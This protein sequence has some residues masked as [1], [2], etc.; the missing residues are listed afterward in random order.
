MAAGPNRP[1]IAEPEARRL[2][3][4]TTI[5][6]LAAGGAADLR[7][8][9]FAG[10]PVADV[11]AEYRQ[12]G[13]RVVYST[14]LVPATKR[15]VKDPRG[16]DPIVRLSS[17]LESQGLKLRPEDNGERWLVVRS[18]Q[19]DDPGGLVHGTV[20]DRRTGQPIADA[21]V[22]MQGQVVTTDIRGR[23]S[24]VVPDLQIPVI[25]QRDGYEDETVEPGATAEDGGLLTIALSPSS[26]VE[27]ILV[28]SP[29]YAL[30]KIERSSRYYLDADELMD[31]PELGD[32]ALR[33]ATHLPGAASIG[34]SARPHIRG[35]YADETLILF[36]QVELIE[37]FHLKDFQSIFSGFSPSLVKSIDVYTGGFP[38]RYGDRMSG[39]MDVDVT[40]D[41]EELG[42]QVSLSLLSAEALGYGS[43]GDK[44]DWALSA[45]RG[46]LD[47]VTKA[48]NPGLGEPSYSDV[49][50]QFGWEFNID[51][52]VDFGVLAY[53][54]DIVI[55]TF[56]EEGAGERAQSNY[57]NAYAW[58]QMH[59]VWS[60][61][62]DST[63]TFS[64]GR[65]RSDRFGI[66]VDDDLADASGTFDSRQDVDV[67]NLSY[68]L[69]SDV[70]TE[71]VGLVSTEVGG[72]LSY[73][74]A[75]YDLV[76]DAETSE[77]G[78]LIGN[79]EP[80][81]RAIDISPEGL[82]G[83]LFASVRL[84]PWQKLALETGVRWDFQEYGA[85]GFR[86]QWGPRFSARYALG[87]RTALRAAAGRFHQAEGINEL[88]VSDGV[89]AFQAA[90]HADHYILGFEH[91]W[92]N[93]LGVRI[94]T[95]A[96]RLGD[97]K[98]RY[99]NLF[100]P[101]VLLPE[102]APDRVMVAPTRGRARGVETTA[103]Y[104]PH[105]DLNAW[106]SYTTQDS[107]DLV[108]GVWT[109]RSWSQDHTIGAGATWNWRRWS[110]SG[111]LS[112]HSGWRTTP[113]PD[114]IDP[115]AVLDIERNSRQ[116]AN[117]FSLDARV[118]RTWEWPNVSVT[119]YGEVTNLT[120]RINVGAT[121]YDLE[122]DEDG[123]LVTEFE[124]ETL[125]PRVPSIGVLVKF[126]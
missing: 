56:D 116:L 63:T 29:R 32:D 72:R 97:P 78:E 31:I 98:R 3:L 73:Q 125:I 42:G 25:V 26:A 112:W 24:V 110:F 122:D 17:A 79:T 22:V 45:R 90:Q 108:D 49:Y 52:R 70:D 8:T 124:D 93:G 27:E 38:A 75:K 64:V 60:E 55:D 53:H 19:A 43:V 88:Q 40:D 119:L 106:V 54:G 92:T 15:F 81:D 10:R 39:V 83:N 35:G 74:W 71:S 66:V 102:I 69:E 1:W 111:L 105:P 117:Y 30:K 2:I 86:D 113:L 46:N 107:E 76:A 87:K 44:G 14:D 36:D 67:V 16:G 28:V 68:L 77:L 118:A 99:E 94:E 96:K 21:V 33:A 126:L 104:N 57:R 5:L 121:E 48:V 12:A 62:A 85:L 103:L 120:D 18:E 82:S 101:L 59:N 7:D 4:A 34:V 100:D 58:A 23:F 84:Q 65:L 51:R 20:S 123:I 37:P 109:T 50:G 95:Y 9:V 91:R 89:T 11:L 80:V 13:Y 114:F 115:D 47:L 41:H 6:C 61:R